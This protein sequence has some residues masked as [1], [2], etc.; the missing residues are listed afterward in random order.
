M[1]RSLSLL[2]PVAVVVGAALLGGC[3]VD[4]STVE[5][6]TP[7]P[8]PIEGLEGRFYG[9]VLQRFGP[10]ARIARHG[11]GFVFGYESF[12]ARETRLAA[13]YRQGVASYAF[14]TGD[15]RSAV[16]LF[17]ASGHLRE[18]SSAESPVDLGW[19]G[20]VGH[21]L[22]PDL[23]FG[24]GKYVPTGAAWGENLGRPEPGW[25]H[26]PGEKE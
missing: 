4:L 18:W 6:D 11:D 10:P 20:V 26:L 17:D 9:E 15:R 2:H 12:H 5:I 8:V 23:F 24:A 13:R 1:S 3:Q 14:G 16:F 21:V 22:S 25:L 19:G 7:L